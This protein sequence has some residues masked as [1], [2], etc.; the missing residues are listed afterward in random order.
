[1][2]DVDVRLGPSTG[3]LT[4]RT[5]RAGLAA[6][7]GH[8]LVLEVTRW[9][10]SLSVDA[11]DPARSHLSITADAGSL[12][13]REAVGGAK[14]LSDADRLEIRRSIAEKV[15]RTADHPE[16]TF[17]STAVEHPRET[18]LRVTG[19]LTIAGVTRPVGFDVETDGATF[20]AA[21]ALRQ[22]TFGIRP[23]SAFMGT[24][25]VA[26]GVEVVAEARAPG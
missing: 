3:T 22:S 7:A 6:R 24:L 8:D 21:V 18:A 19:D 12:E 13:V 23:F 4:V 10:G 14:P 25:K 9:S 16:I 11:A 2:N 17:V 26:D 15:L 5:A 1:V 20:R